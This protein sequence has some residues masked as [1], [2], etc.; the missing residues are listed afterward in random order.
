LRRVQFSAS[1]G[2]SVLWVTSNR[3]ATWTLGELYMPKARTLCVQVL[4]PIY[5]TWNRLVYLSV[6]NNSCKMLSLHRVQFGKAKQSVAGSD[7]KFNFLWS[8]WA[9]SFESS[10]FK[11][12]C[13]QRRCRGKVVV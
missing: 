1:L 2:I 11:R 10:S 5:G 3:A 7:V 4:L 12:W 9:R 8:H 6:S 13:L